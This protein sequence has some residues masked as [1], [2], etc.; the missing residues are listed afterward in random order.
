MPKEES[1]EPEG[2]LRRCTDSSSACLANSEGSFRE[3]DDEFL[4]AQTRIWL[5]ELLHL[6]FDVE[7]SLPDL[8]SDGDLL[9]QVS[10]VIWKMLVVTYPEMKYSK[11]YKNVFRPIV[12]GKIG[13]RYLPYSNA[14]A[15]LRVC[16]IL[17]LTAVDLFT[18]SDVVEKRDVRRVCMC[19]RALSKRAGSK[20]LNV[21]DFDMVTYTIVMPTYVVGCIRKYWEQSRCSTTISA[22]KNLSTCSRRYQKRTSDAIHAPQDDLSLED[23]D[24]TEIS[25]RA[26]G[27][28]S[29]SSDM[30]YEPISPLDPNEDIS[31]VTALDDLSSFLSQKMGLS[32]GKQ[33]EDAHDYDSLETLTDCVPECIIDNFQ[34]QFE[35]SPSSSTLVTAKREINSTTGTACSCLAGI[36]CPV[37]DFQRGWRKFDVE[38]ALSKTLELASPKASVEDSSNKSSF[39]VVSSVGSS[40]SRGTCLTFTGFLESA[41]EDAAHVA[42]SGSSCIVQEGT[43]GGINPDAFTNSRKSHELIDFEGTIPIQTD[44]RF[45]YVDHMQIFPYQKRIHNI[46]QSGEDVDTPSGV[47]IQSELRDHCY[48][49]HEV[50]THACDCNSSEKEAVLSLGIINSHERLERLVVA[51]DENTSALQDGI[52]AADCENENKYNDGAKRD[53]FREHVFNSILVDSIPIIINKSILATYSEPCSSEVIQDVTDHS[54]T[55]HKHSPARQNYIQELFS[56]P[57]EDHDVVVSDGTSSIKHMISRYMAHGPSKE[58]IMEINTISQAEPQL[59]SFEESSSNYPT[60]SNQ[61]SIYIL[62]MDEPE[63]VTFS[64]SAKPT[65]RLSEWLTEDVCGSMAKDVQD[66]ISTNFRSLYLMDITDNKNLVVSSGDTLSNS[67]VENIAEESTFDIESNLHVRSMEKMNVDHFHQDLLRKA[68]RPVICSSG[69][70][71]TLIEEKAKTDYSFHVIDD[72]NELESSLVTDSDIISECKKIQVNYPSSFVPILEP[73]CSSF[74]CHSGDGKGCCLSNFRE[75]DK[76]ETTTFNGSVRLSYLDHGFQLMAKLDCL[77]LE[78]LV[79][80]DQFPKCISRPEIA[81]VEPEEFHNQHK[82]DKEQLPEIRKSMNDGD[83]SCLGIAEESETHEMLSLEI[84]GSGSERNAEDAAKCRPSKKKHLITVAG[85]VMFVGAF[86]FLF[87]LG[88]KTTNKYGNYNKLRG[89]S[90]TA[91]QSWMESIK[92]SLL[93]WSLGRCCE[94]HSWS[95]V[96]S[97][98]IACSFKFLEDNLRYDP[99][100]HQGELSIYQY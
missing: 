54:H 40:G 20:G 73:S 85:G 18:P 34:F 37:H 76:V 24:D 7:T 61:L 36:R 100:I 99:V 57:G 67:A 72:V 91:N 41:L 94:K 39:S 68:G 71:G 81:A 12:Y 6:R 69:E 31:A 87:Q 77:Q 15:F 98:M 60:D 89:A 95:K 44:P 75:L 66:T 63:V 32:S 26:L 56:E 55:I 58:T 74:C 4:Q 51:R 78:N 46:Y 93:M 17:G 22:S 10:W 65:G 82:V 53:Y 9:F 3:L 28:E 8:L 23:S 79:E 16:Q 38:F 52:L 42:S 33:S 86:M 45:A 64:T 48:Y 43:S 83:I 1:W 21:P 49:E 80:N 50:L 27:C 30:L 96:A 59:N 47:M 19:I 11:A 13:S 90:Q 88:R 25:F 70:Q 97:L 29:P 92:R 35:T 14:D 5:G 84:H 2:I 62:E